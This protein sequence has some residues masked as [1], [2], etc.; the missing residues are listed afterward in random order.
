MHD[1]E[2]TAK[3]APQ[4]MHDGECTAKNAQ[5]RMQSKDSTTKNAQ[6]RMRSKECTAKNAQQR[7]HSKECGAKKFEAFVVGGCLRDSLFKIGRCMF[8]P[9]VFFGVRGVAP[10]RDSSF[11]IGIFEE[12]PHSVLHVSRSRPTLHLYVQCKPGVALLP[13]SMKTR[14]HPTPYFHAIV[15]CLYP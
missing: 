9:F 13:I 3:K 8:V 4:R 1:G 2:C 7:M 12:S 10:L 5:Q 14:S 11:Q 15:V 6:Q